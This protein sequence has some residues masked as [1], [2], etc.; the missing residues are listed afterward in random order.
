MASVKYTPRLKTRYEKVAAKKVASDLGITNVMRTP[1]VEKVAINIGL[2]K[3]KDDKRAIEVATNT[4]RKITGQQPVQTLARKS[5]AGFKIREQNPI[6]LK[7]TLRGERMYDFLD[8]LTAIVLPR[9]RDF[10][11]LSVKSFDK[12]GNYHIG[13]REQSVFPELS[14]EDT[15]VLHGVQISIITT[16][17]DPKEGYVLLKELGFPFEKDK[18]VKNG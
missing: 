18:E 7:V 6:G 13:L 16:A 1:K 14:F 15:A 5:I 9:L 11:G 12:S 10:H 3:A 8:R 4:L 17:E 2:G